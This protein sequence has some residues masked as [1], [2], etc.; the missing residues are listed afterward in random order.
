VRFG[1]W[2][3]AVAPSD[4]A[5][6]TAIWVYNYSPSRA[7][8]SKIC[9]EKFTACMTFAGHNIDCSEPFLPARRSKRGICYGDV[10]LWLGSWLSVTRRYCVKTAKPILKLFRPSGSLILVSSDPCAVTEFQG[11][12]I[13]RGR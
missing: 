13:Q 10:A 12:P 6:K 7:Q 2:R 9:F 11:E 4:A 5:D 1:I 8:Q 3:S